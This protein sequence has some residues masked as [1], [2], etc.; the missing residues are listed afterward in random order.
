MTSQAISP[1]YP[2]G[3]V[4]L[5]ERVE[6]SS[7]VGGDCGCPLVALSYRPTWH[8]SGT[9]S[10]STRLVGFPRSSGAGEHAVRLVD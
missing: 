3:C 10:S 1:A 8:A 2:P 9:T 7:S 5:E 4:Q 6:A